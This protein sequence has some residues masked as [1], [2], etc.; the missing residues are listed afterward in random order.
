VVVKKSRKNSALVS[1][2][3]LSKSNICESIQM[4]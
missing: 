3:T 4:S 2:Q 1:I